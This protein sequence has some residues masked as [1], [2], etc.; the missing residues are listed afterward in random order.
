MLRRLSDL[1]EPAE[2]LAHEELSALRLQGEQRKEE[3]LFARVQDAVAGNDVEA[4]QRSIDEYLKRF[5]DGPHAQQARQLLASEEEKRRLRSR[6]EIK[7]IVVWDSA[8]LQRKLQR[9]T[10]Y[11]DD[12]ESVITSSERASIERAI[13]AARR[14]L[15]PNRYHVT[16]VRTS[17]LDRPRAHGVRVLV[18]GVEAA[19]FDDSASVSE[20][21]W[22]RE[23]SVQWQLGTKVE[24]KLLNY[25]YRNSEVATIESRG[26]MAILTLARTNSATRYS[27]AFASIRPPVR[28]QFR[29]EQLDDDTLAALESWIYPGSAW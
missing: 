29:C 19:L 12:W 10:D 24:V 28:V 23:F 6:E 8:S 1:P 13:S 4:I 16:L 2:R 26:P 9:I 27:P 14:M 15:E 25:R 17:G 11:V 18:G 7:S 22:N 5:P 3:L 21:I 20:K